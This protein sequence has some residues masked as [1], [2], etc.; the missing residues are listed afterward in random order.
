MASVPP[1]LSTSAASGGVAG[2][3]VVTLTWALGL[4]HV[5]LPPDV[6]AAF[7]VIGTSVVHYFITREK[8]PAAPE[9][10]KP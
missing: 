3:G 9:I 7:M 2:A 6:A 5:A 1:T 8:A 10:T 4:F